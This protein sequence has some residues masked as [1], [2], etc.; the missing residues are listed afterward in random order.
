MPKS[1]EPFDAA[2]TYVITLIVAC[3]SIVYELLMAQTLSAIMGNTVLRYSITIGVYLASLGVGAIL[4]GHSEKDSVLR[5]VRIEIFLSLIGGLSV[6]MIHMLASVQRYAINTSL[7]FQ[8]TMGGPVPAVSFFVLTHLI[9]VAIGVLSGYEVPLLI[10]MRKLEIQSRRDGNPS[11][12]VNVVLG[13]DYFG[14]LLGA[15]IFPLVL[16]P[17]LGIF[18]IS[19]MSGLL[20]GFACLLL[21]AFKPCRGR[22][23]QA[24]KIM[25]L[26]GVLLALL[27]MVGRTEQYFLKKFYHDDKIT[28]I[29]SIF[30]P[31]DDLDD[32]ITFRSPYQRIHFVRRPNNPF[33]HSILTTYTDKFTADPTFPKD[34]WLFMEHQYQFF[35]NFEEM[36]HEFFVHMPIQFDR[37]P[38][39][40]LVLGAGDGLV[41]RELLKYEEVESIIV[42]D[43]DPVI[44]RLAGE[45]PLLVRMN[46]DSMSDRRVKLVQADAFTWLSRCRETFDAVYCDFPSPTN[47][48]LSRLFSREFYHMIRNHL[49]DGGFAAA[50]IPNPALWERYYSTFKAAGFKTVFPYEVCLENDNAGLKEIAEEFVTMGGLVEVKDR[51][52][53]RRLFYDTVVPGVVDSVRQR[54]VYLRDDKGPIRRRYV[55]YKIPLHV[56]NA[57]RF[58][59]ASN[60]AREAGFRPELVNSVLR[61]T[62]PNVSLNS[63][64][65]LNEPG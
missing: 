38:R 21:L 17:R 2:T 32:I 51:E 37:P 50:D 31:F 1:K 58:A 60:V 48:D 12:A 59:L 6:I 13:V 42:A 52:K 19:Y 5:L 62:I 65:E 27:S 10:A 64:F 7:F 18:S 4:C 45:Y 8:G 11:A 15:V 43:I 47:F 55:D 25:G 23:R 41:V 26:I 44:L 9:I 54:F 35:S 20:N 16:L 39:R 61:P 34:I 63:I 28:N 40:V 36:Y 14:S 30:S 29:S 33:L 56:F 49:A 22:T 46:C 57:K 24:A 53:E 3:C